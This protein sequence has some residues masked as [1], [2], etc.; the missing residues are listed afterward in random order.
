MVLPAAATVRPPAP[1]I[2]NA[3]LS[4]FTDDTP[5]APPPPGI[6]KETGVPLIITEAIILSG[7]ILF[8]LI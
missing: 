3:P 8:F 1:A 7:N 5:A 2:D 4:A 6:D